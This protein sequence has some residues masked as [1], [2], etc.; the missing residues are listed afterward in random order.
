[1]PGPEL[2][3]P[4]PPKA[5]VLVISLSGCEV[6]IEIE[7]TETVDALRRRV[8]LRKRLPLHEVSFALGQRVL[9]KDSCTLHECGITDGTQLSLVVATP[10]L[11]QLARLESDLPR[12]SH[13]QDL[14]I[15]DLCLDDDSS[16]LYFVDQRRPCFGFFDLYRNQEMT[17]LSQLDYQPCG[18]LLCDG[19]AV[20]AINDPS[21]QGTDVGW[22][23]LL[24]IKN[25]GTKQ[26]MQGFHR[27]GSVTMGRDGVD[28]FL[29]ECFPEEQ[30]RIPTMLTR[31][32][33]FA[34][35]ERRR[36]VVRE[37]PF[38]VSSLVALD[39][40]GSS[41]AIGVNASKKGKVYI[42]D[43]NETATPFLAIEGLPRIG[44]LAM[45]EDGCLYCGSATHTISDQS[46]ALSAFPQFASS[47][48]ALACAAE[49][50]RVGNIDH[51]EVDQWNGTS[52]FVRFGSTRCH[53][54]D[55]L[56]ISQQGTC[57]FYGM[58]AMMF[59][60]DGR[61]RYGVRL[62]QVGDAHRA[63]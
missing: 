50:G 47:R 58:N 39:A 8:A 20:V 56:A 31:L 5:R 28:I 41:F 32:V 57:V 2:K 4:K 30:G 34:N 3:A 23:V 52:E 44:A 10:K 45:D 27:I 18:L 19:Q 35:G 25:G 54:L 9:D 24:D 49:A 37:L 6:S 16:R 29:T 12:E 38:P 21:G 61:H 48:T 62:V 14:S 11:V 43:A 53:S 63:R 55:A 42:V 59:A 51:G 46:H 17:I 1:M 36:E 15:V 13:F 7:A 22:L 33:G 40:Q 26:T 60:P